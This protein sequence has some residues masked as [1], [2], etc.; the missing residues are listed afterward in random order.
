MKTRFLTTAAV[1]ILSSALVFATTE[2][3]AQS[4]TRRGSTG[5][6]KETSIK[7]GGNRNADT[8]PKSTT[9]GSSGR[10]YNDHI[11]NINLGS[12]DRPGGNNRSGGKPNGNDNKNKPNNNDNKNRPGNYGSS[13]DKPNNHGNDNY[14]GNRGDVNPPKATPP[15]ANQPKSNQPKANPPREP[16]RYNPPRYDRHDPN[17]Y[18]GYNPFRDGRIIHRPNLYAPEYDFGI[19]FSTR[20][21]ASIKIRFGGLTLYFSSGVWYNYSDGYYTVHRPPIGTI[22]PYKNISGNLYYVDFEVPMDYG[23]T[24]YVDSYANFYMAVRNFRT[25]GSV[26]SLQVVNAPVG[27]ILYDLPSDYQEI[28]YNGRIYYLVGNS[29]FDYVYSTANSWYFRCIG[30]YQ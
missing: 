4:S 12:N 25:Y 15:K 16:N 19:R 17:R 5:G 8:P 3:S 24:Y 27:A 22:I 9:T 2:L 1:A 30:L 20:P 6:N 26:E 13:N 28:E 7:A 10:N 29:V 18:L 14:H 23:T 11:N 21:S